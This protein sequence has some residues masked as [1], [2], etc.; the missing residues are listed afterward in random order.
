MFVFVDRRRQLQITKKTQIAVKPLSAS[1]KGESSSVTF[2][3]NIKICAVVGKL[4]M[5]EI[6]KLL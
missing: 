3:L 5:F 4:L 2:C 6:T 1:R